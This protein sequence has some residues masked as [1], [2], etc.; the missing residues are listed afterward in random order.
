MRLLVKNGR[1]VDPAQGLD[2]RREVLIEDGRILDLVPPGV[3]SGFSADEVFRA[4]GLIVTPGLIDMHVHLREPGHE[5]KETIA[6][7]TAAAAAGGFTAVAAMPNTKPICDDSSGV[8]FLL[9]KAAKTA[10]TRVWP[11]AAM[12]KGQEGRAMCE[13]ADLADAGAVGVSDDGRW[14]PDSG[15]MRRILDYAKI[16]GLT[17]ISHAEE[18]TLSGGVM[19]E[20]PVSTRL[21]LPGIPAAAEEIAVYRDVRL[22][23]LTGAPIHIAHVST[24]G[25]V[26]IIRLAKA[27]GVPVTAETAPHYFTL[28]DEEVVG[29]R[30]NA[31]MNPPL[32]S[33]EDV[34]AIRAGLADG[35]LDAIA[36]DHAPHSEIEKDVEF[37]QAAFGIVGLETALPLTLA[38]VRDGVIDLARAIRLLSVNPARILGVPGGNLK[39][40]SPADLTIIDLNA[41]WIADPAEFLSKS[42]NTPFA[43]REMIGR[44]AVVIVGGRVVYRGSVRQI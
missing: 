21:G 41:A 27:K 10:L 33:A 9:A 42:R 31:K 30:T 8:E 23:E 40:G 36:T 44:A 29:F 38:L 5:Y 37:D 20:G 11:I 6:T 35:T 32:R 14:V 12:T 19:N 34:A 13:Y 39:P 7:G 16:F 28:T 43:G 18:P 26:E 15:L 24:K 3:E 17:A 1:V 4:D 2:E 25:A 22:A